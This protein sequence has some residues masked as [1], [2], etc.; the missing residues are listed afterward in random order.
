M[1]LVTDWKELL[2][3][4]DQHGVK[5]MLIGGYA[6]SFHARPRM[7]Q[8]LD[9]FLEASVENSLRLHRALGEFGFGS[10]FPDPTIFNDPDLVIVLGQPSVK[11]DLLTTIPGVSFEESYSRRSTFLWAGV[12]VQVISRE[13]LIQ[14]KRASGRARD[15]EDVVMLQQTSRPDENPA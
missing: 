14:A 7:T 9:L 10:V 11:L 15:L 13:D 2:T 12:P 4:F 5:Y 3:L 1:E 6:V 8:A